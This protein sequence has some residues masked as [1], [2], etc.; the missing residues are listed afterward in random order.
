MVL[1]R[2]ISYIGSFNDMFRL[3]F[4]AI[5]RLITFLSK[6]KYTIS[7]AIVIVTYEI[8]YNI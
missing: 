7:D 1:L 5:F 4:W 6:V 8:S 3:L 2:C